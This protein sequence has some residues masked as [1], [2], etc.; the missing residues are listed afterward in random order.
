MLR[1]ICAV[2]LKYSPYITLCLGSIGMEQAISASE[3]CY[4]GTVLQVIIGKGPFYRHFS[5]NLYGLF[6]T[7]CDNISI[8]HECEGGIEKICHKDHRLASRGLPSDDKQ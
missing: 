8:H 4:K 1:L 5:I 3:S 2:S 6:G 7:S